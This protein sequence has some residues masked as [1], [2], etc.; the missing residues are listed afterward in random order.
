MKRP[1]QV[2]VTDGWVASIIAGPKEADSGVQ[3]RLGQTKRRGLQNHI[4]SASLGDR[5]NLQYYL[6]FSGQELTTAYG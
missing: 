2:L 3:H 4:M 5:R 6:S 1:R